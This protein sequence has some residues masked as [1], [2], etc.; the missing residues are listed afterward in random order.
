MAPKIAGNL[1]FFLAQLQSSLI[2][3][4]S[5]TMQLVPGTRLGAYEL[6]NKHEDA[7]DEPHRISRDL[8]ADRRFVFQNG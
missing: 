1:S 8:L 6:T 2:I 4:A 7:D 3:P 5:T